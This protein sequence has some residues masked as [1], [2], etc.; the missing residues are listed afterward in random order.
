MYL[1]TLELHGFKSFADKTSI[2]LQKGISAI[3]GPNGSGKS[4][5]VEAIQWVLGEQKAKSLRGHKME[6]LIFN[7]TK[8]RKPMGMAEVSLILDNSD[9][10]F[11]LDYSEIKVT[12]RLYRSGDG[13]YL[14]NGKNC[15]LKDI[16]QL[17]S[18]SGIGN[19]GYSVIGQGRI[20]QIVEAR[21]EER[22]AM[23]EETAGVV[24]YRERKKEALRKITGADDNLLRLADIMTE[25]ESRLGPLERDS[26]NAKKYLEYKKEKDNLSI[27]I[28]AENALDAREKLENLTLES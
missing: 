16:H 17:F 14:I 8:T 5:V 10:G 7:G 21:P 6:D 18:D 4:N 27:G 20:T 11:P 22:R 19:D 1:K 12:R 26:E 28:L 23:V 2:D 13:E 9:F 25:I 15:R 24:K 3:V